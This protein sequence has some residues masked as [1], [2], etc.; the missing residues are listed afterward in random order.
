MSEDFI[1]VVN[2]QKLNDVGINPFAIEL[3]AESILKHPNP[4][5]VSFALPVRRK[6]CEGWVG[7]K[8][9]I[10]PIPAEEGG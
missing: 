5:K 8:F 7:V 1:P 4:Q 6:D 9:T 3:V 10:E 2:L